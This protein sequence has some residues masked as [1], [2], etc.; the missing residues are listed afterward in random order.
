MAGELWHGLGFN[1]FN[2]LLCPR[3]PRP[4]SQADGGAHRTLA[5]RAR[6]PRGRGSS[7]PG[8]N[9][10][11][12]RLE[13]ADD[14]KP[15]GL[16]G[17]EGKQG[18]RRRLERLAKPNPRHDRRARRADLQPNLSVGPVSRGWDACPATA[19]ARH[20]A[21]AAA[22]PVG[23]QDPIWPISKAALRALPTP[24][25]SRLSIAPARR[26][27]VRTTASR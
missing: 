25:V 24:R 23:T 3:R 27:E 14:D 1:G 22:F 16:E 10:E 26:S 6:E 20:H 12:D 17:T 5:A 8:R 11:Q 21:K 19:M 15:R 4:R 13:A 18:R 9:A 7:A 2:P